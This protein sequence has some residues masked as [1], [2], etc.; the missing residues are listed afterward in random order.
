VKERQEAYKK[1][2]GAIVSEQAILQS[3]YQPLMTHLESSAGAR[4][5]ISFSVLRR[6][7]VENWAAE[8]ESL[9]DLR[10]SGLLKGR[11]TLLNLANSILKE[12]WISGDAESASNAINEFRTKIQK[13]FLEQMTN[14]DPATYRAWS[15][16]FA[17]WLYSTDHISIE[18]SIDYG[19]VD[20]RKLS[21]GTRGIVL[22]LLY[23]ALDTADE[24]PL[25]I[26]QPEENLDPQ[27]IFEELVGLF[28]SAKSRRQVIIV[29]HNAN[30]VVNT[31]ADQI[32]IANA[33]F[34]SGKGL[35][36]ITYLSG[37]L[38]SQNIRESVCAILEGGELALKERAR[39]LRVELDRPS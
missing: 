4:K 28:L 13:D 25:I 18:Y 10:V 31:D 7:N 23:L 17:Q 27:S 26:D 9:I 36:P 3:L 35:P 12:A 14:A 24:R 29:T 22:L 38:E 8:G 11:G 39:R 5:K 21:P 19:G 32:I 16:K 2:L 30:L 20:I 34:S 6:V 37:G 1:V 15:K 33:G